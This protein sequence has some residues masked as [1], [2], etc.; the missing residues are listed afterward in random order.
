MQKRGDVPF[1]NEITLEL[2]EFEGCPF[3]RLVREAITELQLDVRIYPCPPGGTRFRPEAHALAGGKTTFPFLVDKEHDV[4]M[5][6]S[7]DIIEHLWQTRA[8]KPAPKRSPL[9][10]PTSTIASL[11]RGRRGAKVRRSNPPEKPLE[12]YSFESSPFSRL[13]RETLCELEIPYTLWSGGKEQVGDIGPAGYRL[14]KGEYRPVEGGRR[15]T[16]AD[17][18][19]PVQFPVLVDPNTGSG[20]EGQVISESARI[21]THLEKTYRA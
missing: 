3:C 12:L 20:D 14:H 18:G 8:G 21:I 5:S 15:Q 9:A 13:V 6:E 11:L 10:L 19:Y 1:A 17:R 2:Y 4:M 16:M 7:K